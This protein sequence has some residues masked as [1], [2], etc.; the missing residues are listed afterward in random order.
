[1]RALG[2]CVALGLLLGGSPGTASAD[3]GAIAG[4]VLTA[5]QLLAEE[6]EE[7]RNRLLEEHVLMAE[8]G[9]SSQDGYVTAYVVFDHTR[10][11]VYR[12]LSQTARQ[13]EF[14]PELAGVDTVRMNHDGPTDEHRIRVLFKQLTYRLR[15]R[16]DP[17]HGRMTWELDEDFENDIEKIEGFWELYEMEDGRTLARFGAS[18]DVGTAVPAFMQDWITRK[19]IPSAMENTRKWV[20]SGGTFRP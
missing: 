15:Y 16:L 10:E 1:M 19:N 20:D 9:G 13:T 7:R 11:R 2:R 6:S 4:A 12:F 5:E 14:R 17:Q 18:V 3:P 8:G